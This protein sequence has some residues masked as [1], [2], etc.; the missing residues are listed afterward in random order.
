MIEVDQKV[1][2]HSETL[3]ESAE[4]ILLMNAL[5]DTADSNKTRD[6]NPLKSGLSAKNVESRKVLEDFLSWAPTLKV[7]DKKSRRKTLPC[8]QGLKMTIR[9]L[10][11]L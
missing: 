6:K 5:T 7:R 8:F 2:V 11:E 9:G 1:L 10:L 3:A 4:C